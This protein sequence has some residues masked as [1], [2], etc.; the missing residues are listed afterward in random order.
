MLLIVAAAVMLIPVA[1]HTF[2]YSVHQELLL[3]L[4]CQVKI[5]MGFK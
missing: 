2:V 3:V 5:S 4:K 1:V